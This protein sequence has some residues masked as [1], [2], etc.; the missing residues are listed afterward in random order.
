[1][2]TKTI[3]TFISAA[4]LGLILTGCGGA[5]GGGSTLD[6]ALNG[7]SSGA[8]NSSSTSSAVNSDTLQSIEFKDAKPEIINLKGTGGS[9]SSLVRIRTLGQT[10][11]PI[12]GIKVNF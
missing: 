5:E 10:G 6:N 11:K 12:K 4:L 1:M 9:E 8:S 2:Q 7:V 3:F